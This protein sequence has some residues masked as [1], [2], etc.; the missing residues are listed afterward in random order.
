MRAI[1][2]GTVGADMTKQVLVSIT[3]SQ[4]FD[5]EDDSIELVTVANYYKR[6]GHHFVLYEEMPDGADSIIKNTLKFD[7]T[8]FEMTK[9]GAVNAQLLFKPRQSNTTYYV[10][11]A[12]P[13]SMN[14]T[15][16]TYQLLAEEDYI[17]IFIKYVLDI[18]YNFTTENEILIRIAPK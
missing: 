2:I 10:T 18:N 1:E 7:E 5:A 11:A 9:K 17:E 13:M 12:G 14:V 16:T 4:F 3:G 6:N 15:T 8:F